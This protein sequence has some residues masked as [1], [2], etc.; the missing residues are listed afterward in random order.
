M[1][2]EGAAGAGTSHPPLYWGHNGETGVT[3][4]GGANAPISPP[5][6]EAYRNW[7]TVTSN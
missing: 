3:I 2:S 5:S 7:V 6:D 1:N 4:W